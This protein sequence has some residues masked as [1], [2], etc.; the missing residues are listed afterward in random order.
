MKLGRY[1][2]LAFDSYIGLSHNSRGRYDSKRREV[3][4]YT[5]GIR[6]L[7]PVQ[8]YRVEGLGCR[9]LELRAASKIRSGCLGGP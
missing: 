2:C 8:R 5:L 1:L 6:E 3:T 4:G 9:S 7:D